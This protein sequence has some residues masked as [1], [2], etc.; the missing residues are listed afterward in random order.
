MRC[1]LDNSKSYPKNVT[2]PF[3]VN[4]GECIACC[5]P[6][7]EAPDLMAFDEKGRSCFFKKQPS[8]PE[9]LERAIN[10]VHVSCTGAV[11]YCGNDPKILARL[12]ELEEESRKR[13]EENRFKAAEEGRTLIEELKQ[14]H[15]LK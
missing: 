7:H 4:D 15:G 3:I 11:R 13:A 6:E 1:I 5:A 9:E 12:A 8:T 2:G 14:K 10:A